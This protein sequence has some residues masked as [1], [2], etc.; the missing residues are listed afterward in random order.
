[1]RA[2]EHII[3]QDDCYGTVEVEDFLARTEARAWRRPALL[4]KLETVFLAA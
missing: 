4:K 3:T 2:A 1:L